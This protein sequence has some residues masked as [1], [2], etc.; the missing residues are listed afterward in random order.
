MA[1][2]LGAL[3]QITLGLKH[4]PSML[5]KHLET[6]LNPISRIFGHRWNIFDGDSWDSKYN[7][8]HEVRTPA[9]IYRTYTGDTGRLTYTGHQPDTNTKTEPILVVKLY[10]HVKTSTCRPHRQNHN[11]FFTSP[12]WGLQDTVYI[13]LLPCWIFFQT[14][15][16]ILRLKPRFTKKKKMDWTQLSNGVVY[17]V[18]CFSFNPEN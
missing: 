8:I 6:P 9:K 1:R 16:V 2:S 14:F 13:G 10:G 11:C 3:L 12:I 5:I 7:R 4:F 17:W 18:W 15:L